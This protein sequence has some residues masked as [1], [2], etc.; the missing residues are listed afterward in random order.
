V[1]KLKIRK[2]SQYVI[3]VTFAELPTRAK[4]SQLIAI[5][6]LE[7]DAATMAA[8]FEIGRK[9]QRHSRRGPHRTRAQVTKVKLSDKMRALELACRH[10]GIGVDG[11]AQAPMGPSIIF[12][13][14]TRIAIE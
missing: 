11:G 3:G 6:A 14:G 2:A 8:S 5:A 7:D 10:L 4:Q 12:P 9:W 13:P 1:I